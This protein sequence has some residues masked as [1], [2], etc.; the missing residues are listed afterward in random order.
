MTDR[1][2]SILVLN[3]ADN[4]KLSTVEMVNFSFCMRLGKYFIEWTPVMG[5][6]LYICCRCLNVYK[7]CL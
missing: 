1:R 5:D 2:V 7:G 4:S 6:I 3:L